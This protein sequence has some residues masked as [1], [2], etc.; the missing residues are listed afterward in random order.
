MLAKE[1]QNYEVSFLIL[2]RNVF[3]INII[4]DRFK[5]INSEFQKLD[6]FKGRNLKYLSGSKTTEC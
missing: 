5:V 4:V 1:T 6:I 2:K 3:Y